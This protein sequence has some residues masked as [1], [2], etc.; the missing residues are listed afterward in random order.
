LKKLRHPGCN[1]VLLVH[2]ILGFGGQEVNPTGMIRLSVH[3]GDKIK[4]KNLKLDFLVIDVPTAD[5]VILGQ[6]TLHKVKAI[7]A[8][9][10]PNFNSKQMTA[11]SVK[12]A[13]INGR[14]GS[15][16]W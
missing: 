3:F 1:I 14:P 9:C 15:A 7:I 5:N 2:P 8:S 4:S 11:V 10:L 12:C 16:T 13:G 6:P